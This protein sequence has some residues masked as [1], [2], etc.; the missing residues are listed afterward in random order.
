MS[1]DMRDRIRRSSTLMPSYDRARQWLPGGVDLTRKMA[2]VL[3]SPRFGDRAETPWQGQPWLTPILGSGPLGLPRDFLDVAAAIPGRI[4]DLLADSKALRGFE[5]LGADEQHWIREFVTVLVSQ[6]LGEEWEAHLESGDLADV[7]AAPSRGAD[8][9]D[10]TELVSDLAAHLILVSAQLTRTFH[11]ISLDTCRPLTRWGSERSEMAGDHSRRQP[12]IDE[13]TTLLAS[14]IDETA[15][16]IQIELN[17]R[18]IDGQTAETLKAIASLIGDVN[19]DVTGPRPL[20]TSLHLQQVTEVAW[21]MLVE[22]VVKHSYPGWTDLLLRLVLMDSDGVSLGYRRPRWVEVGNLAESVKSVIEPAA[23]AAWTEANNNAE[24]RENRE[25]YNSVAELLWAQNQAR[26]EWF[27]SDSGD[28]VDNRFSAGRHSSDLP[29]PIAFVTSF[30]YELEMAL[31]RSVAAEGGTFSVV[32]P[33]YAVERNDSDEADFVWLEATIA[34]PPRDASAPAEPRLEDFA[35]MRTPTAWRLVHSRRGSD[36]ARHPY[37]VRLAGCPLID[38]PDLKSPVAADLRKDLEDLHL[39]KA[40]R[41]FHSVTVDEYL[42]L[43]QAEAEWVWSRD[44]VVDKRPSRGLAAEFLRTDDSTP[45]R[46]WMMM[47]VPLRDPAIR[48]RILALL[49]R[50]HHHPRRAEAPLADEVP[51]PESTAASP[52]PVGVGRRGRLLGGDVPVP[53]VPVPIAVPDN[54]PLSEGAP[55]ETGHAS[56][57]REWQGVAVNTRVDDEENMLLLALGFSVVRDR[58]EHLTPDLLS[59]VGWLRECTEELRVKRAT[60]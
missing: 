34:I 21:H 52:T 55:L 33:A 48:L 15:R 45:E 14:A 25:F 8:D 50:H 2:E 43:R 30:D 42:A 23:R 53:E 32:V 59:H 3:R 27:T 41:F 7:D 49:A 19:N 24:N 47:G 26:N 6:R 18:D 56:G 39:N 16:L 57:T 58:C 54:L 4:V 12:L 22:S 13:Y 10:L 51:G 1:T 5:G 38:L 28:E 9:D 29:M 60:A 35:A 11:R 31:W 40:Q 36:Y 20:I 44:N 46:Y 37:V 17:K